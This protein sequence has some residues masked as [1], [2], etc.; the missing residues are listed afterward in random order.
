[1]RRENRAQK[2][3]KTCCFSPLYTGAVKR[4]IGDTVAQRSAFRSRYPLYATLRTFVQNYPFIHG[5]GRVPL[6]CG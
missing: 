4:T 3:Q 2:P 6:S 5:A 1:M